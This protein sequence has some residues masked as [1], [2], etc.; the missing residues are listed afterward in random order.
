MLAATVPICTPALS[1]RVSITGNN[2]VLERVFTEIR[3]QTGLEFF[4]E[5]AL[6]KAARPVS[7][8]VHDMPVEAVLKQCLHGQGLDFTV[9]S[10][11]IIVFA[12]QSN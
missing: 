11:T 1:Q 8:D 10:G 6:L 9:R 3:K 12:L 4:Y 2:L 7:L 5:S